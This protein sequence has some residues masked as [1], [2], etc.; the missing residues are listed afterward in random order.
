LGVQLKDLLSP[1]KIGLQELSGKSVAFDGNNILYQFLA[2]IRGEDGEALYDEKGRITSHLSG[3]IYRNS[4]LVEAGVK[5]VYVFDGKPPD[6]KGSEIDRRRVVRAEARVEYRKALERGAF[7]EARK[8]AQRA[9]SATDAIVGDAKTLLRLMGIPWVQAPSEGEAQSAYMAWKGDV[10]A[11]GSQ[12]FDSL[13]F[14]APRLVR[15]L[16]ITGRRKLPNKKLYIKIEPELI[17]LEGLLSELGVTREQLIDIGILVGTDFNPDGVKG[18]GP[19]KALSLIKKHGSLEEALPHLENAKFPYPI[20]NIRQIF[21]KPPVTNNYRL[22]WKSPDEE[23]ILE[24][25]CAEHNFSRERVS[26]AVEK[27]KFG[28]KKQEETTTLDRW[29]GRSG[30]RRIPES[31]S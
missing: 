3:L 29:F 21:L 7:E 15:N 6:L 27:L 17:E 2:I 23:G 10:W 5:V 14:G 25:L 30:T 11:S 28:V 18:I 4:N 9:V 8:Y 26:K 12:D 22:E 16:S 19:K 31:L 20:E 24:F 13:L 1:S